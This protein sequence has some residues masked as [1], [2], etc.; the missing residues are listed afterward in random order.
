MLPRTIAAACLGGLLEQ[1]L[2]AA[3]R[4]GFDGVDLSGDDLLGTLL[5]PADIRARAAD[6]GLGIGLY[7]PFRDRE[8]VTMSLA[9][10][11]LDAMGELGSPTMLIASD[12][13]A[14]GLARIAALAAD[15]GVRIA[16]AG[17]ASVEHA[18]KT[19]TEVD[20]PALGV[21]L[22][23]FHLPTGGFD[24]ARID[25]IPPERIFAVR[26]ADASPTDLGDAAPR[27]LP[28]QGVLDLRGFLEHVTAAGHR[29]PV[30]LD[31]SPPGHADADRTATAC[32][33]AL[34]AVEERTDPSLGEPGGTAF[35]EITAD[36]LAAPAVENLLRRSGFVH[37]AEHREPV[38]V[39]RQG[40]ARVL[41]R[42]DSAP[43]GP[44]GVLG[45]SAIGVT[46]TDPRRTRSAAPDGTDVAFCRSGEVE[47]TDAFVPL[48]P[49]TPDGSTALTHID[50]IALSPPAHGLDETVS[51]YQTVLDLRPDP[52]GAN[53]FR[54]LSG[55]GV[56]L[57]FTVPGHESGLLPETA[58][59]Q[60]IAFG[61][62]DIF[63]AAVA[64]RIRELPMPVIGD[65]YFD[66]L[67]AR[68]DL[69][70]TVIE[71]MRAFGV[72]YDRDERGE[73][74]HFYTA[75]LGGRMFFEMVQRVNGYGGYGTINDGVRTAAQ[76]R[77]MAITDVSW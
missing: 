76:H 19:V 40:E 28:G 22:D 65:N 37:V 31:V 66:D 62:A 70:D 36:A 23:A 15:S 34:I 74:F 48:P 44:R 57:V 51:F 67:A 5:A 38:G 42:H 58:G 10:R 11:A 3:A 55:G 30:S 64:M 59:L 16:Y 25:E 17:S 2:A 45:I 41:L 63:T 12:T 18:W 47:R 35:V 52:P 29:G 8:A 24:R 75:V 21:C 49:V 1:K 20:D 71:T 46:R 72:L 61:C 13:A 6:L 60:H 43:A 77:R 7:R 50:H 32:M 27:R 9:R 4:A 26:L 14:D 54:A 53:G 68:F 69:D 33:R 39:W 56:R 73:F